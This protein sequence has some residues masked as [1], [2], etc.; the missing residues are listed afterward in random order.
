MYFPERIKSFC[1]SKVSRVFVVVLHL[2]SSCFLC[3]RYSDRC[4]CLLEFLVSCAPI[5]LCSRYLVWSSCLWVSRF[6]CSVYLVFS[7]FWFV[8]LPPFEFFW[9]IIFSEKS[10]TIWLKWQYLKSEQKFL[11]HKLNCKYDKKIL[12][13]FFLFFVDDYLNK[14]SFD[15]A[16]F[17]IYTVFWYVSLEVVRS[18]NQWEL[19]VVHHYI[20]AI[21]FSKDKHDKLNTIIPDTRHPPRHVY[22]TSW[23]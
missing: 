21:V 14:K 4:Y 13:M 10:E 23:V 5:I 15:K 19:T 11:L 16:F 1:R 22:Y 17:I 7:L 9:L 18:N 6:L 8:L 3:S 20:W 12:D 2:S